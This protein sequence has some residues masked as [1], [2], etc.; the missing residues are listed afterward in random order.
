M[1]TIKLTNGNY[2]HG[3][4]YIKSE[5]DS[6]GSLYFAVTT[7]KNIYKLYPNEIDSII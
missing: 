2:L 4:I 6:F 1:D 3:V 7:K 5:I